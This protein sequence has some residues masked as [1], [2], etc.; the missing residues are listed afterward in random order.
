MWIVNAPKILFFFVEKTSTVN[1]LVWWLRLQASLPRR[2]SWLHWLI[3]S[4][5]PSLLSSISMRL[6]SEKEQ[7]TLRWN[8]INFNPILIEWVP[9][10]HPLPFSLYMRH[11]FCSESEDVK[12]IGLRYL[13]VKSAPF[14]L[15][16]NVSNMHL[17]VSILHLFVSSLLWK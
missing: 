14:F 16:W 8:K 15:S 13:F 2:W 7:F 17:F 6:V 5:M 9:I 3:R 10:R 11:L 1:I 12:R 4:W